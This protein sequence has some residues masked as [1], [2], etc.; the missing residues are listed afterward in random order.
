MVYLFDY[1]ADE[2]SNLH[3]PWAC[4]K[5]FVGIL[6][7][8]IQGSLGLVLLVAVRLILVG[9]GIL[10]DVIVREIHGR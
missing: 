6:D 5:S 1:T 9:I 4:G 3:S 7:V 2:S 8:I 10:L